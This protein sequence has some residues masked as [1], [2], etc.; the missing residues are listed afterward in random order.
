MFTFK[1][2]YLYKHKHINAYIFINTLKVKYIKYI[3][4]N[5]SMYINIYI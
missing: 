2:L 3:I 5:L 4:H 1:Y